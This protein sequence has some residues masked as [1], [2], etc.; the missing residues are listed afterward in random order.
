MMPQ[1]CWLPGR[2]EPCHRVGCAT[3]LHGT[4]WERGV[5]LP[6][7]RPFACFQVHAMKPFELQ[8][9]LKFYPSK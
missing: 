3:R 7:L 9:N 2:S 4:Q 6:G 8:Y 5:G 1:I